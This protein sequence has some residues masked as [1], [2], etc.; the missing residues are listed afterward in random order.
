MNESTTKSLAELGV[1]EA[2]VERFELAQMLFRDVGD[3]QG[4][5]KVL[6]NLGLAKHRAGQTEE[7]QALL[8]QALSRLHP[9]SNAHRLVERRITS[10]G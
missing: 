5:G 6:A 4:E 8:Q 2:A 1:Q 3:E 10:T 7:A 9:A